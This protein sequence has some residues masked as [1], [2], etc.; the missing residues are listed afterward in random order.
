MSH[1]CPNTRNKKIRALG[2]AESAERGSRD[3]GSDMIGNYFIVHLERSI[4]EDHYSVHVSRSEIA[5]TIFIDQAM[6]HSRRSHSLP[7]QE[8]RS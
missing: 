1:S 2:R 8:S 6:P 3:R 5:S 4:I 7:M